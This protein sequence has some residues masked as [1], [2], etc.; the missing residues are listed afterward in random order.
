MKNCALSGPALEL[1]ELIQSSPALRP[2][3]DGSPK[4]LAVFIRAAEVAVKMSSDRTRLI[5]AVTR[6]ADASDRVV[7]A[8]F[9]SAMPASSLRGF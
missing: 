2:I 4:L 3:V 9:A 1:I 6:A 5:A 8:G 7:E